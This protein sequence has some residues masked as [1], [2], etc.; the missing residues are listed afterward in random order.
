MGRDSGAGPA[1]LERLLG[2]SAGAGSDGGRDHASAGIEGTDRAGPSEPPGD[3]DGAARHAAGDQQHQ[4]R[5]WRFTGVPAGAAVAVLLAA[6]VTGAVLLSDGADG[7]G[8]PGEVLVAPASSSAPLPSAGVAASGAAVQ[9]AGDAGGMGDA[10]AQVPQPGAAGSAPRGPAG[11][12]PDLTGGAL[13]SGPLVVHVDGAVARPGVVSVPVGSRVSDAVEAA[14]G[15]TAEADTRL[16]NLARLLSDGEQVVVPVPGEGVAVAGAP[17]AGSAGGT[18]GGTV[19][20]GGAGGSP[21]GGGAPGAAGAPL[22]LN[23]ADAGALDALPGIGPVL[24]ERIVAHRDEVGPY[25]SVD[26]LES[27]SGIGPSVLADIRD[28]V[29]V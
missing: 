7:A 18:A 15:V 6:V 13:Q 3:D 5:G 29:T 23:A 24:A 8:G 2:A 9:E 16:V 11:A 19:A 4:G 12:Q 27:V 17:A 14:G 21:A 28:L 10:P 22:D 20:A 25:D 1:R 26:D